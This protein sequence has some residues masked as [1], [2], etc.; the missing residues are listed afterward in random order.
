MQSTPVFT[1]LE[2]TLTEL[3]RAM[4]DFTCDIAPL[5]E[6]LCFVG[7]ELNLLIIQSAITKALE[8]NRKVREIINEQLQS[9]IMIDHASRRHARR[10]S[11]RLMSNGG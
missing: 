5:R 9:E 11:Y 7:L 10:S 8:A 6:S 2:G 1:A 4:A 3:D